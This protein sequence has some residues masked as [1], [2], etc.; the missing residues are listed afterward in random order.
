[1][2][3]I[4]EIQEAIILADSYVFQLSDKMYSD[5]VKGKCID[6][7]QIEGIADLVIQLEKRIDSNRLDSCT[8]DLYVCLLGKISDYNGEGLSLDPNASIPGTTIVIDVPADNRPDWMDVF[9]EMMDESGQ[10]GR[11]IYYNPLWLGFNPSLQFNGTQLLLGIDYVLE[12]NGGV[13]F[14]P[15]SQVSPFIFPDTYF[16]AENYAT[17]IYSAPVIT[18]QPISQEVSEGDELVLTVT[19]TNATGYQWY[20]NGF[21]VEGATSST[22]TIDPVTGDDFG[23]YYCLVYN[24]NGSYVES[25]IAMVSEVGTVFFHVTFIPL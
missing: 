9:Y 15:T 23:D 24:A 1:M 5:D 12:E 7:S 10:D 25:D 19:A 6:P 21:F 4:N 3:T 18:L 2:A 8:D 20:K 14:L 22:L 16:R 13:R 11:L 17:N